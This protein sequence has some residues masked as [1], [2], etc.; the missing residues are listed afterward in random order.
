[1]NKTKAI[2]AASLLLCSCSRSLLCR[3]AAIYDVNKEKQKTAII[4]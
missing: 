2:I 3:E 1:M 4:T